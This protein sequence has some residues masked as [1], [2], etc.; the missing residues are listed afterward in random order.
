MLTLKAEKELLPNRKMDNGYWLTTTNQINLYYRHSDYLNINTGAVVGIGV[1][2]MD[3]YF[4]FDPAKLVGVFDYEDLAYYTE[5]ALY[6]FVSLDYLNSLLMTKEPLVGEI[7]VRLHQNRNLN[8]LISDIKNRF[9]K[10]Y[11]FILPQDSS[12]LVS[13]IYKLTY[14]TIYFIA[15]LLLLMVYLCSSFL[16]NLSIE[17]RRQEI[18]I[19]MAL[20]VKKWRIGLLF[21]GEFLLVMIFFGLLGTLLGLYV[22]QGISTNGIEAT[23]IPLHLIFGRSILYIQNY[24]QTFII[25]TFILLIAF[26]G[27]TLY[28]IQKMSKLDPVEVM[29]DL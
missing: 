20:G 3:G 22:M 7:F 26:I 25:I 11:R 29:R 17:T 14:F 23:I 18:G 5:F 28:A 27:N 12:N 4:N 1:Q 15:F 24:P 19:Y 8:S 13:G 10:I 6:A 16:V 2:T 21:G 9:G